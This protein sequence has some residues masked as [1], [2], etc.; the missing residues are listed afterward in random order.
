LCELPGEWPCPWCW[1]RGPAK[2][3]RQRPR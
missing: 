1:D 3:K 2:R